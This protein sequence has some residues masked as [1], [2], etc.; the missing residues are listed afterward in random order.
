MNEKI[1]FKNI[2]G[3]IDIHSFRTKHIRKTHHERHFAALTLYWRNQMKKQAVTTAQALGPRSQP[4]V[5]TGTHIKHEWTPGRSQVRT[6][7]PGRAHQ[8]TQTQTSGL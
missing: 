7:W 8:R 2:T 4:L 5:M 6:R 1:I 3:I